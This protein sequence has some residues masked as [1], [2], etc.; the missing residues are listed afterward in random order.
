MRIRKSK[1]GTFEVEFRKGRDSNRPNPTNRTFK[2]LEAAERSEAALPDCR[3]NP[4]A[5]GP[6]F[7]ELASAY[8]VAKVGLHAHHRPGQHLL[9]IG[10]CYTDKVRRSTG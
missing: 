5:T 8:V 9:Q 3:G 7:H 6:T 2:T 10:R 1:N 4:P